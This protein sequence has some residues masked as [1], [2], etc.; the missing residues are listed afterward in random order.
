MSKN[1]SFIAVLLPLILSCIINTKKDDNFGADNNKQDLLISRAEEAFN[2]AESEIFKIDIV[3]D[4][5]PLRPDPDPEK[6][7]CNGTGNIVHGDGHITKCPFHPSEF[8]IK[9]NK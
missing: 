3:P 5:K 6:C 8:T 2:L 7:V 4:I 1:I 9:K